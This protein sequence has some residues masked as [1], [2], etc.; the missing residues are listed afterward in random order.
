MSRGCSFFMPSHILTITLNPAIDRII[1]HDCSVCSDMSWAGGKGINVARAAGVLGLPAHALSVAGGTSGRL[2]GEL[3]DEERIAHT[4]LGIK[5]D[6]RTN[7]TVVSKKGVVRRRIEAGPVLTGKERDAVAVFLRR[8]IR[9]FSAAVFSGSLP[10]GFPVKEFAALVSAA[11]SSGVLTVVDTSGPALKAVLGLG[12]DVIK[13]NRREAEDV[14]GFKLSSRARLRKALRTFRSYGIKK[15]LISLGSGGLA[16]SDGADD[17]LVTVPVVRTGHAV[18]CGDAAL[19]GFLS[20]HFSGRD[21]RACAALSAAC[22][23]ANMR[24]DLPGGIVK[25]N[26][27]YAFS[28]RKVVWL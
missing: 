25:K 17:L 11:R 4:F 1:R 19:A 12:V 6:T 23:H 2:L 26:V 3:L 13:P 15:V 22:G 21:L 28:R 10:S 18:G 27:Q 24:T 5:G 7:V 16:A 20:A 8:R 9:R 14:L